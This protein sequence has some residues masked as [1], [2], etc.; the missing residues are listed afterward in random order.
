MDSA[1]VLF[2]P[3]SNVCPDVWTSL[4]WVSA[5]TW[6]DGEDAAADV[7]PASTTSWFL[8]E[9]SLTPSKA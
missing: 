2:S 6:L 9:R 3:S 1:L 8:A 4:V 5:P 7:A